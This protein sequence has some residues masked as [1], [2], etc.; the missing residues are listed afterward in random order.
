MSPRTSRLLLVVPLVGFAVLALALAIG[1]DVG[2]HDIHPSSLIGKPFPDFTLPDLE[3]GADKS[4]NDLLGQPRLVNVWGSWCVVCRFEHSFFTELQQRDE[5]SIVGI[6]Y[7]DQ[8]SDAIDWLVAL[9]NPFDFIIVDF[10]GDL[11]VD[12][13]V[14]GAPE[15]FLVDAEGVILYKHVG[16]LSQ[17]IWEE[18]FQPLIVGKQ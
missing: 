14:Y 15:T 10:E 5:I 7:K 3:S 8:E 16:P 17:S 11:G 18:D 9:G 13:G 6:N 12:L 2:R 4:Q 1:F